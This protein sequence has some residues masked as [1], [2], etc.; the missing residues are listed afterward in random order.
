ML[1]AILMKNTPIRLKGLYRLFIVLGICYIFL[2][3]SCSDEPDLTL[4]PKGAT[5]EKTTG[6]DAEVTRKELYERA[7]TALQQQFQS[8]ILD[9]QFETLYRISTSPTYLDFLRNVPPDIP[10]QDFETFVKNSPPDAKVYTSVLKKHFGRAT[11][12]DIIVVH[13][14]HQVFQKARIA[15]YRG[16][17]QLEVEHKILAPVILEEPIFEW[18]LKRFRDNEERFAV[19]FDED[20]QRL[21]RDI[22]F[23]NIRKI[24]KALKE[25]RKEQRPD[26]GFIWLMLREPVLMGEVLE[27]F[28]DTEIF[29]R[30]L[31]GEFQKPEIRF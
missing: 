15:I 6:G 27:S 8:P 2:L 21:S 7:F 13:R 17:D 25:Q 29:L 14:L 19:F 4:E 22:E 18:A 9:E 23:A 1:K 31:K 20:L 30:W 5:G 16:T 24:N 10:H 28:T 3:L 11:E 12:E 26:D